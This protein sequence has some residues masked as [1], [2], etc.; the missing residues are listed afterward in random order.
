MEANVLI[1]RKIKDIARHFRGVLL[2]SGTDRLPESQ[3]HIHRFY[4]YEVQLLFSATK[5][6]IFNNIKTTVDYCISCISTEFLLC[7]H[8]GIYIVLLIHYVIYLTYCIPVDTNFKS[9]SIPTHSRLFL[10]QNSD[11]CYLVA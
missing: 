11:Q 8:L 6:V 4:C 9:R 2:D 3:R 1:R 7:I 5:D 10:L